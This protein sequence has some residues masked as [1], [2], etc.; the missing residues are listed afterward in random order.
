MLTARVVYPQRNPRTHRSLPYRARTH[1]LCSNKS[2]VCSGIKFCSGQVRGL[3]SRASQFCS[4]QVRVV[5]YRM[6]KI[7]VVQVRA[8]QSRMA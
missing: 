6:I 8:V 2:L 4:G 7:C 3:Q 5:Q 1:R